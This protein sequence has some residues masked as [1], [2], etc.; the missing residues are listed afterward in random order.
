MVLLRQEFL[1]H[2]MLKSEDGHPN[3]N[4]GDRAKARSAGYCTRVALD[5]ANMPDDLGS[6]LDKGIEDHFRE[7]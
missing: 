4:T 6:L 2:E 1:G 5:V 3:C 7:R